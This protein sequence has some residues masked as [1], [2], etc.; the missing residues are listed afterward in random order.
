MIESK[1]MKYFRTLCCGDGSLKDQ[2]AKG[3]I[4]FQPE[5]MSFIR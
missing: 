1:Q 4:N 3:Q 5:R 2:F